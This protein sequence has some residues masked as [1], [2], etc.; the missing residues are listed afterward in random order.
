MPLFLIS[1]LGIH[2][3]RGEIKS[4]Q[5]ARSLS[6]SLSLSLSLSQLFICN[7]ILGA[8]RTKSHIFLV[9]RGAVTA[10]DA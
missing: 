9:H 4:K 1:T 3:A 8:A 7:R 6:V 10:M 5:K 2:T